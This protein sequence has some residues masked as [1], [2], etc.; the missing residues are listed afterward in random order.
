MTNHLLLLTGSYVPIYPVGTHPSTHTPRTVNGE[1]GRCEEV[2]NVKREA[3]SDDSGPSTP[4]T[5]RQETSPTK[6]RGIIRT[7]T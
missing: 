5:R 6:S 2:E 7:L 3:V 4:I 1:V